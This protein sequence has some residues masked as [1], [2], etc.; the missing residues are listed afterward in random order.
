MPKTGSV[1]ERLAADYK[2]KD[3]AVV[4][5]EIAAADYKAKD[6]VVVPGAIAA[7]AEKSP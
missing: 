2:A 5:G 7:A 4:P 3:I 1:P 6:I